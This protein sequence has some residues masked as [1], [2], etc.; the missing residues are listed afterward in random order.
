MVL[1]NIIDNCIWSCSKNRQ[2]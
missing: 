1:W 2:K